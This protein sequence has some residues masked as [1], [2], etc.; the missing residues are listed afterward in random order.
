MRVKLL[1]LRAHMLA[2][3]IL[4]SVACGAAPTNPCPQLVGTGSVPS[5]IPSTG[6]SFAVSLDTGENCGWVITMPP[7]LSSFLSFSGGNAKGPATIQVVV[8]PH[9]GISDRAIEFDLAGRTVRTQ[10]SKAP[11][12]VIGDGA[13]LFYSGTATD[14][15]L[16]GQAGVVTTANGNVPFAS[17]AGSGPSRVSF[18]IQNN[19]PSSGVFPFFSIRVEAANGARLAPGMFANAQYWPAIGEQPTFNGLSASARSIGCNVLDGYFEI[20]QIEFDSKGKLLRFHGRV[21]QHCAIDPAGS[22]AMMEVW[23]PSKGAVG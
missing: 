4:A 3:A 6:G 13:V 12:P 17:T 5:L 7:L 18:Q 10:Q 21:Y 20:F 15:V 22:T 11:M 16:L 9:T 8:A 1:S 23:Y 19:T 2:L 14:T